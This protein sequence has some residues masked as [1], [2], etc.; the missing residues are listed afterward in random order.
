MVVNTN[1]AG[2]SRIPLATPNNQPGSNVRTSSPSVDLSKVAGAADV[3]SSENR[4]LADMDP[5]IRDSSAARELTQLARASI[6]QQPVT[7]M[8]AQGNLSPDT[9]L[10]L[11][12][13]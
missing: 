3:N 6:V 13:E 8:L 2:T 1:L 7:A 11:L 10:S 12:Q 5:D 9:V 4:T